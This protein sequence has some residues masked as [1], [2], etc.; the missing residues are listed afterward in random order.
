MAKPANA[1]RANKNPRPTK[2]Q[3]FDPDGA[4]VLKQFREEWYHVVGERDCAHIVLQI[5]GG[6]DTSNCCDLVEETLILPTGG[7]E[8]LA[9][10]L[11]G[12]ARGFEVEYGKRQT[13]SGLD[14]TAAFEALGRQ[15]A[16]I[17]SNPV[18][19]QMS[20]GTVATPAIC[21]ASE[22]RV[23]QNS[24]R[25]AAKATAKIDSVAPGMQAIEVQVLCISEDALESVWAQTVI[26]PAGV[27]DRAI[28]AARQ[29]VKSITHGTVQPATLPLES[30][31]TEVDAGWDDYELQLWNTDRGE[32]Q[33]VIFSER[34]PL[35]DRERGEMIAQLGN[36]AASALERRARRVRSSPGMPV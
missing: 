3:W 34:V 12:V 25:Y 26:G 5:R 21:I 23:F 6:K 33:S 1:E 11:R 35:T 27:L 10:A 2:P 4:K 32:P 22:E 24:D 31:D 36:L 19:E 13:A 15:H 30:A 7:I 14:I 16:A 17:A 20:A 29:A 8:S 28:D 18:V 9:E